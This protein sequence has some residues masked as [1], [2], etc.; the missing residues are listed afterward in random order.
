[1]EEK[2]LVSNSK[3]EGKSFERRDVEKMDFIFC[4]REIE[5]E[6]EER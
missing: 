5:C 6:R 1:M 4:S 3:Q 2:K